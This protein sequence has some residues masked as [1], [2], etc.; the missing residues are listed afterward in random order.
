MCT[1]ALNGRS[2]KYEPHVRAICVTYAHIH[3]THISEFVKTNGNKAMNSV[4]SDVKCA[5]DQRN[6]LIT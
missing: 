5:L 1:V 3:T 6:C 2:D 4:L